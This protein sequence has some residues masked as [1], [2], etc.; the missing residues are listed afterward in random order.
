MAHTVWPIRYGHFILD[1]EFDLSQTHK[2]F[3]IYTA[4]LQGSS[5]V[6]AR[7]KRFKFNQVNIILKR[8]PK[9]FFK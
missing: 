3:K 8:L 4:D 1:L 6:I 2:L 5:V 9:S 7:V